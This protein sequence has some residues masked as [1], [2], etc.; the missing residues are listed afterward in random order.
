[1]PE[2]KQITSHSDTHCSCSEVPENSREENVSRIHFQDPAQSAKKAIKLI[3]TETAQFQTLVNH[4]QLQDLIQDK[5]ILDSQALLSEHR[6][7]AF[8][9]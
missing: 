5:N 2:G 8:K 1:M 6:K 9:V 7:P 3:P 4:I